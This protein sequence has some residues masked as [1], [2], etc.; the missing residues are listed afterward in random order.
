MF[1]KG[2][3]FHG[4]RINMDEYRNQLL[5]QINVLYGKTLYTYVTHNKQSYIISLVENGINLIDIILTAI[6]AVGIIN[7]IIAQSESAAIISCICTT[8]SLALSL[9]SRGRNWTESLLAHNKIVDSLWL[10]NQEYLSLH[11]DFYQLEIDEIIQK[12]DSL[13]SRTAEI[14]SNAPRTGKLAY[15]LAQKAIKEN[16]EQ[17]FSESELEHILP[18]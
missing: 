11:T 15:L 17:S 4:E 5:T 13:I 6:S 1:R 2:F 12:R 14:Y 3:E 10:I 7:V 18:H 16:N 9:F 8:V